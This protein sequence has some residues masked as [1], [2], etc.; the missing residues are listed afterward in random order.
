MARL[1]DLQ[2]FLV[3]KNPN[4]IQESKT[5]SSV[6][7]YFESCII[8]V[9]DH[10]DNKL[11]LNPN[12]MNIVCSNNKEFVVSVQGRVLAI[13]YKEIKE[14]ILGYITFSYIRNLE[15]SDLKLTHTY[16][17]EYFELLKRFDELSV[18]LE[19]VNE[20]YVILKNK[21]IDDI[22]SHQKIIKELTESYKNISNHFI[23]KSETLEAKTNECKNLTKKLKDANTALTSAE[24]IAKINLEKVDKLT[25]EKNEL[26]KENEELSERIKAI[27]NKVSDLISDL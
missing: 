6:Y 8:R 4:K 20:E 1:S 14:L 12:Y 23:K 17:D 21:Q 15:R 24:H 3:S 7:Y 18:S 26:M 27:S 10:L 11:Q 5:S 25:K 9:S 2:K 22:H 13:P 16:K 19:K